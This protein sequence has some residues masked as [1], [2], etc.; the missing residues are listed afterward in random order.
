MS[1]SSAL[2]SA[3]LEHLLVDVRIPEEIVFIC[4]T[5]NEVINFTS[6]AVESQEEYV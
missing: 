4:L 2:Q 6:N 5:L 1:F 3:L